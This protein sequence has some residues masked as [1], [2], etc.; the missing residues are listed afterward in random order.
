MWRMRR[1][2]ARLTFRVNI[3]S[4]MNAQLPGQHLQGA[5]PGLMLS[6]LK[7]ANQSGGNPEPLGKRPLGQ[8]MCYP[9]ANHLVCDRAGDRGGRPIR[10]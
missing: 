4:E 5:Q 3:D 7:P 8:S 2:P 9:I 1:V 6:Q 10:S